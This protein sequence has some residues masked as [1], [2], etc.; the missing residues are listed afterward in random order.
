MADLAGLLT[1][2]DAFLRS[3]AEVPA[4]LAAFLAV[5]GE[6]HPGN[7]RNIGNYLIIAVALSARRGLLTRVP[8]VEFLSRTHGLNKPR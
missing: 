6:Q 7:M 2:L 1:T 4:L 5:R 3:S 8:P